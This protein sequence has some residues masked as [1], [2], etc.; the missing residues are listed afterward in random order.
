MDAG[1]IKTPRNAA[2][3]SNDVDDECPVAL[4]KKRW[5]SLC[6]H[7]YE[8]PCRANQKEREVLFEQKPLLP[9]NRIIHLGQSVCMSVCLLSS[10]KNP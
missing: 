5:F 7:Y 6:R 10:V 1:A 2:V 4:V 8:P 9:K 3:A